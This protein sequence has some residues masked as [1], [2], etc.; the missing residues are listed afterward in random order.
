M[1]YLNFTNQ[2]FFIQQIVCGNPQN[3]SN[4]LFLNYLTS[5]VII[6]EM[7]LPQDNYVLPTIAT[8]PIIN[9]YIPCKNMSIFYKNSRFKIKPTIL[10]KNI[11]TIEKRCIKTLSYPHSTEN[12]SYPLLQILHHFSKVFWF[13]LL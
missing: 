3:K 10:I 2:Y 11:K 13:H 5:P 6:K 4:F 12:T 1:E 9:R 8:L 7:D